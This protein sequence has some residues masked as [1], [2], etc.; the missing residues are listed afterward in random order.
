MLTELYI[1][2]KHFVNKIYESENGA[3]KDAKRPIKGG[4]VCGTNCCQRSQ[5]NPSGDKKIR[6][7]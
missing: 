4:F 6:A 2:V 1:G 5:Q 3:T 7:V